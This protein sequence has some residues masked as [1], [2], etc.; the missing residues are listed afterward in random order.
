M[1]VGHSRAGIISISKDIFKGLAKN[2]C[3][4]CEAPLPPKDA[5][6][7]CLSDNKLYCPECYMAFNSIESEGI[8]NE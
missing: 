8:V 3:A 2:G 6:D 1:T 5:F 7:M 4:H